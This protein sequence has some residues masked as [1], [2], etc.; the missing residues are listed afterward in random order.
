MRAV[1]PA[2]PGLPAEFNDV[3]RGDDAL[4][5]YAALYAVRAFSLF[6]L[7]DILGS[8]YS[9]PRE[10]V[11]CVPGDVFVRPLHLRIP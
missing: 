1:V 9:S 6:L 11:G 4:M 2:C 8:R 5:R 10:V 7:S 3:I